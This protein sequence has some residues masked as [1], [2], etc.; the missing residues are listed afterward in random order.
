MSALQQPK[1]L[2]ALSCGQSCGYLL[3]SALVGWQPCHKK[4]MSSASKGEPLP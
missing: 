3:S 4:E 1:P 2:A